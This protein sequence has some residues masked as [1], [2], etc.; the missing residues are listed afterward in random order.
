M[1]Y[2]TTVFIL[3]D[4]WDR[5]RK[6]PQAFVDGIDERMHR[7][8]DTIGQTTVM[9]TDHAD[10]FR[11]YGTWQNSITE[12]SRWSNTTLRLIESP[13]MRQYLLT[14]IDQARYLLK[15]LEAEILKAERGI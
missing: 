3:N 12:L 1:G 11:L 7:G 15:E 10:T 5:I 13:R 6:N 8:G 2:N 4:Q 9:R 14:E